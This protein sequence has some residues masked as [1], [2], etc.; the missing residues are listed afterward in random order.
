MMYIK[1]NKDMELVVT[2]YTPIYRGD[3]MNQ[4]IT[5]LIP[6]TVGTIRMDSASVYLSY[7]RA[8]G[9]ADIDLLER[10]E[11]KYNEAYYQYTMPV[12]TTLSRYPGEVC[13]WIQ[14]Y[15]GHPSHPI[16]A[17]SS[18]CVI[19]VLASKNMD[20]YI[21][22]RKL[23]LIYSIQ[24]KMENKLE[25]TKEFVTEELAKKA[26]N[27]VFNEEDGTLQLMCGDQAIGDLV[28]IRVKGDVAHIS[29]AE[30][31]GDGD[32][33]VTFDNGTQ[34]NLGR[35]TGTDG[36]VYIPH[37]DARRVL[38]FTIEN[39]PNELPDPVDLNPNDEWGNLEEASIQT[40][41][42]WEDM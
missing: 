7:I 16:I 1:L 15:S 14:V 34:K 8:D 20:E 38:T 9:T 24:R 35:V 4:K 42:I 41:Y 31:N 40:D 28:A 13:A 12:T 19:R 30:I 23:S 29:D 17:K 11:E 2:K 10:A 22:D 26:D 3:H 39:E 37:V 6:E 5:F 21:C 18:E 25:Q 33:I 32:L 36:A 27:V